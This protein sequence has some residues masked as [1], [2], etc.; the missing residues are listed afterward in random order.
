MSKVKKANVKVKEVV[1]SKIDFL[2]PALIALVAFVLY[3]NTIFHDY[4]LDDWG[5]V[6]NNQFVQEGIKGIPKILSVDLW[7]FGNLNLGYYRPLSLITFA[8]EH[9]FFGSN[10][11]VSHLGNVILFSISG[12]IL[13]LLLLEIFPKFHPAFA[14][15][16][17]L[18]FVAHPLHTEVVANIKSRDEI[19]SFLNLTAVLFLVVRYYSSVKK[20]KFQILAFVLFYLAL[21]SKETS[22]VGLALIP[23]VM[24]FFNKA[25][26]LSCIKKTIPFFVLVLVFLFQKYKMMGS[27]TGQIPDDIVNYPYTHAGVKL[28]TTFLIFV[29]CIKLLILPHPLIYDY[30]YNQIPAATWTSLGAWLGLIIFVSLTY[31]TI[32]EFVKKSILGFA[33]LFFFITIVPAMAF[34]LTR[35]G[36]MAER[37]LYAPLLGFCIVIVYFAARLFKTDFQVREIKM[38]VW[39][40][41]NLILT[42]SVMILFLAYSFKTIDRNAAWK[43]NY[44]LFSTDK[45]YALNSCQN[46]KHYGS[47]TINKAMVE[48]DSVKRMELF[49]DGVKNL[50]EAVAIH[51]KFGEAYCT[52]GI[53]FQAVFVNNDSAM[54][55]YKKAIESSPGYAISYG[56]LGILY[57]SMRQYEMASYY[58][59]RAVEINPTFLD[60]QA[61]GAAL[62]KAT[63]L[64]VHILPGSSLGA[65]PGQKALPNEAG[66][67]SKYYYVQGTSFAAKGDFNTA[68]AYLQKS[69][70]LDPKN[71]DAYIN[72]SNC[73]G[74]LKNYEASIEI[75]NKF[76]KLFGPSSKA[77]QNLAVTY[78]LM[79][80][81]RNSE[82]CKQKA[83]EL[84]KK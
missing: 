26:I 23:L 31:V 5:A 40:K 65:T 3:V 51:P 44:T 38:P 75:T 73:Y 68:I 52:L 4:V 83:E 50:H 20:L 7:H 79:G 78:D 58:Y 76:I 55:F 59:N 8:L 24:Y 66:H 45:K 70:E 39:I 77:Y 43:N 84:I 69:I 2:W 19:L 17:S 53:A 47:E 12:F 48:K 46:H 64:D 57:Q 10:P 28:P 63:G 34:V 81:D 21:L 14:F 74:M 80:D 54:Y 22:I 11:H 82:V 71:A 30:S 41:E 15:L 1:V 35:G 25:T 61:N 72:L 49:K 42:L 37:F 13:C 9:E 62:R 16:I 18:L 60:A 32:K 56:N 29:H 36:I 67:D 6:T 33:L 27:L